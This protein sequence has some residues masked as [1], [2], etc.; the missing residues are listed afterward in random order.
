MTFT[1]GR[2]LGAASAAASIPWLALPGEA[3]ATPLKV[4]AG[5]ILEQSEAY[6]AAD[7]GFFE[8]HGI[9]ADVT[10][11]R[12]GA[13]N[14]AAVAGGDMQIGISSVL[15]LGQ[16]VAHGLPFVIIAAGAVHQTRNHDASL[17]VMSTSPT[18]NPKQLTGKV[19]CAS[20]LNGLD[21]LSIRAL[22]DK[23]GGDSST[24][25]FTEIP[26]VEQ[27][28]AL[29]AG[30]IDAASMEDP[31][32][33]A[34]LDSGKVRDLGN[35]LNAIGSLFVTTGWFTTQTWLAANKDTARR[36][37]AAIYDAGMWASQ[38]PSKAGAVLT[39]YLKTTTNP[40]AIAPYAKSTN[41]RDFQPLLD[42]ASTYKFLPPTAAS[43]FVWDGK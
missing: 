16:S 4:A 33:Q 31:G 37:A 27:F 30:R 35:G 24:V 28:A 7:A 42:V 10:V 38:N 11:F 41:P 21:E 25:K 36:F 8:K 15:Q 19:V 12:G 13:A 29:Q 20:S 2:W 18:T 40:E 1:R 17:I 6:F 23:S 26:P 9:V 32:R 14:A 34:A 22:I 5:Q 43:S 39:K 3:Q